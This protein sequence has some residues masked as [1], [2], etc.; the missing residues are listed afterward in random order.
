MNKLLI[1]L[2]IFSFQLGVYAQDYEK[3]LSF[4]NQLQKEHEYYR[5]ITEYKRLIN[6]YPT[7]DSTNIIRKEIANCYYLAGHQLEAVNEYKIIIDKNKFD[8][9]ATF[10]IAVLLHEIGH[11]YESNDFII[12]QGRIFNESFQDT[13]Y[14][15]SGINHVYLQD[16]ENAKNS[17]KV[18]S[19]DGSLNDIKNNYLNLLNSLPKQKNRKLAGFLNLIIPGSGY[20]YSGRIETSIATLIT[21]SLFGTLFINSVRNNE[22]NAA[23]FSGLVFSGFYLG[24]VNGAKQATDKWN[25]NKQKEY[26]Q[27][28]KLPKIRRIK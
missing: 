1:I 12:N 13:L 17:F 4:A 7:S 18:L 26:S 14:L 6:Y 19:Y 5:A 22:T 23:V 9:F 8:K 25:L 27:E 21:N 20:L 10:K 16:F 11:Y 28:F 15:I 2:L 24:S 3:V